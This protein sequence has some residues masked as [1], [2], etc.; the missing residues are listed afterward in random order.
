VLV[1]RSAHGLVRFREGVGVA[2]RGMCIGRRRTAN[3][4]LSGR[5][6]F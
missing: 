3:S 1:F 5:K 6:N 4:S 2:R